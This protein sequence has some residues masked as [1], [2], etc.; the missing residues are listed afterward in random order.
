MSRPRKSP[1]AAGSRSIWRPRQRP[2]IVLSDQGSAHAVSPEMFGISGRDRTWNPHAENFICANR[3]NLAALEVAAEWSAEATRIALRL[4]PDGA[5]GAVPLY[6]PDTRKM[7]AGLVVRPRYGWDQIGPIL[8]HIGWS[9]TPRILD[10]PLVPGSAREV[11]PWVLAGPV[12]RRLGELI[13]HINSGFR[14]NEE[15]RQSPRGQI[16]WGSYVTRQAV[17]GAFHELPCR[18]PELGPDLLLQGYLRWGVERVRG[19]LSPFCSADVIARH[20][21]HEADLLLFELR[22]AKVRAPDHR[23]LRELLRVEGMPTDILRAGLQSLGWLVDERGLGEAAESDG[24][25]WALPMHELFERWVEAIA[26]AWARRFGGQ[27]RSGHSGET[28]V[29]IAWEQRTTGS[30]GSL[31]PDLLVRS[32]D[33]LIIIDAKYK[34]HFE[35]LDA[36][37]WLEDEDQLREEHRR[38]VHQVLAYAALYEAKNITSLLVYPMQPTTWERLRQRDRCLTLATLCQGGRSLKLALAGVPVQLSTGIHP[39]DLAKGW[40]R[41]LSG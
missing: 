22:H 19:S 24:L 13:R 11:P 3:A 20:L 35:E 37:R 38:D 29:P 26:R 4:R 8:H 41:L 28:I 23:A 17:R 34:N 21:A 15:V 18:Y 30:L 25:A 5:V 14:M 27:L 7:A 40:G 36:R 1:P 12:L 32:G 39:D 10:F 31:I 9:A 16:L 33:Q 6:A 2:L